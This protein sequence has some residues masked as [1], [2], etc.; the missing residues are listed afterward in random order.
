MPTFEHTLKYAA[1]VV[2]LA[3]VS[4]GREEAA[5]PAPSVRP[6]KLVTVEGAAAA[7]STKYPAVIDAAQLSELSFQ[8]GGLLEAL[9]VNTTQEVERG[10][11][12]ARLDQ[13]DF[14]SS[15]AEADA[16][17][18]NAD[19]MYQRAVRLA[20]EDAI[21]R[22]V[23]EERKSQLDVAAARLESVRKALNDTVLRA[24]F[25]GVVADVPVKRLQ[26]V[27]AGQLIARLMSKGEFKATIQMPAGVIAQANTR[28]NRGVFVML[29]A[30]P[31]NKIRA[32]FKEATLV[33][34]AASQ[35]YAVTFTF[36]PPDRLVILPGMTATVEIVSSPKTDAGTRRVTVPLAAVLSDGDARFVWVV[37]DDMTVAKRAVTVADGI[38]ANAVVTGGLKA[39]EVVVGA[40]G[41]NVS[42]GMTVRRWT[43][44]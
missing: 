9:P 42:A 22:S 40:G 18:D 28:V 4:C 21:A 30:A 27:Q 3:L 43:P 10:A 8:V 24:P 14:E 20:K 34:D 26:N 13:R 31:E 19:T 39:G 5:P 16:Q 12:I 7:R 41:A 32:V 35:T 29:D 25:D 33:A 38:G 11:V 17:F 44:Q 15:V 37:N 2:V 1:A 6:V 23:L 36:D